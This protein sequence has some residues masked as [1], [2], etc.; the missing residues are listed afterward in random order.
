MV[1]PGCFHSMEL[2]FDSP[3]KRRNARQ[4]VAKISTRVWSAQP[5]SPTGHG[6]RA[7]PATSSAVRRCH[8]LMMHAG[9]ASESDAALGV[10]DVRLRRSS[11]GLQPLSNACIDQFASRCHA[12]M[13]TAC[14]GNDTGFSPA[15]GG[16]ARGVSGRNQNG[17][18][19]L[20]SGA[21]RFPELCARR[22]AAAHQRPLLQPVRAAK[23]SLTGHHQLFLEPGG[24][25]P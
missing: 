8:V 12:E 10:P 25:W 20:R 13:L 4:R 18:R 11:A 15:P 21:R 19:K 14:G 17:G 22:P 2:T 9:D 23:N 5:L 1:M 7:R 6:R 3:L 24:A 16:S